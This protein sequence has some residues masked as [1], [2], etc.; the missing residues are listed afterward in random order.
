MGPFRASDTDASGRKQLSV[1][2]SEK[3]AVNSPSVT[4]RG[5]KSLT[6]VGSTKNG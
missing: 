5:V 6:H 4:I 2:S 3:R 1:V